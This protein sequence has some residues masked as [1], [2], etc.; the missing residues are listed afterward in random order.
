MSN[1]G[2]ITRGDDEVIELEALNGDDSVRN[3]SGDSF[4]FTMKQSKF[5]IVPL[6]Q[7]TSA[8]GGGVVKTNTSGGLLEVILDADDFLVIDRERRYY[9]EMEV[10]EAGGK[11]ATTH[12]TVDF[13]LDLG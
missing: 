8:T 4:K 11:K 1:L 13:L 3:I 6:V 5:D 2:T 7:K 12:F 9:A 10:T